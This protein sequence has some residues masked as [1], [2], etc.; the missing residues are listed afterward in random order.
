MYC[1]VLK[2]SH[3]QLTCLNACGNITDNF[4]LQFHMVNEKSFDLK[5]GI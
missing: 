5:E 2:Y 1:M 4:G 3:V